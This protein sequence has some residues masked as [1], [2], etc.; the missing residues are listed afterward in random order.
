MTQRVIPIASSMPGGALYPSMALG[1][2]EVVGLTAAT[3]SAQQECGVYDIIWLWVDD[4]DTFQICFYAVNGAVGVV[5][6]PVLQW[7]PARVGAAW[8]DGRGVGCLTFAMTPYTRY[9]RV[10]HVNTCNLYWTGTAL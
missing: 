2:V 3:P 1:S 4:W 8:S 9:F 5:T 6:P 10:Q 7:P